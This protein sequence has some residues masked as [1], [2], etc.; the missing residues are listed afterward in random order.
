MSITVAVQHQT[1]YTFD[2]PVALS[3]HLIRLRPA[4]HCRTPIQSYS[5]KISPSKYFIN[6]QQ[7]PFGNYIARVVFPE[8]VSHLHIDVEVIADMTI[9]N[10]FDFF[11]EESAEH[12]PFTYDNELQTQLQPYLQIKEDGPLLKEWLSKVVRS[13]TPVVNFLVALNQRLQ[14]DIGYLIREEPGVQSCEQTLTLKTGSC[15]DS[16]WLLVQIMRHLGMAAR[17]VS[18]Y[19]VQLR[20]D[21]EALD[22]PSGPTE[23]FTDLHAW[24][25]VYI[26]GAGWVG[27]DPTSGLFA[28]E[29]HIPLSCTPSPGA[30][31]PVTGALEPCGSTLEFI[32]RV[33][34]LHE[35]TRVTA[36][37]SEEAWQEAMAL[38]EQIDA[39]LQEHDIRLTQ[40]G[41]PTFIAIDYPD[42]AEWHTAAMG[43]NKARLADELLRRLQ[44]R[45]A[46]KGLLHRGQGKW[47]P[48]EQ[49]PRWAFNCFF[50]TDGHPL[51]HDETLISPEKSPNYGMKQARQFLQTLCQKLGVATHAIM[52]A[53]EDA[54]W[55][56][57]NEADLPEDIDLR[58]TDLDDPL[59]RRRLVRLL[60]KGLEEAT[61]L[62]LP[63]TRSAQDENWRA[64]PWPLRR[65]RLILVTG[66]S[67]MGYRLPL[68]SLPWRVQKDR[69]KP[70]RDS[71]ELRPPLLSAEDIAQHYSQT[72][73][74]SLAQIQARQMADEDVDSEIP[75]T[76]LCVEIRDGR[77]CIFLPPL[78]HLEHFIELVTHIEATAKSCKLTIDLEGYEPPHDPRLRKLAITPDPGVIE[79]NIHPAASWQELVENTRILYE[80]ARLSRLSA[81][82][83]ML[84][85]RH[86]GTGGG[87]HVT[88][89]A[90]EPADSPFLRRPELLG[91]LVLYWQHHPSLSYL[92]SG[93][94]IGPTSQAPR[95][96]EARD[97]TLYDLEIALQQLQREDNISPWVVDRLFRNILVDMTGNTHR[98]EFCIDK[99]YNPG[100]PTGRLGLLELRAFEMPPHYQMSA[101]QM[102][103]LRA[104][105]ARFWQ[106]PYTGRPA[107]WGSTL[108]DRF[109]LPHYV[110]QDFNQVIAE[111]REAGF[112]IERSWYEAFFNFRFPFYGELC[113]RDVR[114][115]LRAAIEPWNVLGEEVSAQGTSRYV[116]SSVERL[117]VKINKWNPQRYALCCN[118]RRVPLQACAT[119]GDYV[120]GIRFKAWQPAFGLHPRLPAH[121]QLVFDV[122]DLANQRSIAGCTYHV[123]HPGGRNFEQLPVNANEAEARRVARFEARGHTQGP[124]EIPE[125]RINPRTPCTLDLRYV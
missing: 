118:G 77:L 50:R 54:A 101:V 73:A 6:W 28:G 13:E 30:A 124:M 20:A 122:V 112:K 41:E 97:D 81:E 107:Y 70:E 1:H 105:V 53:Y 64:A 2:R 58:E 87:N 93:L 35:K 91:S 125:E 11:V 76:A 45:F 43:P 119:T 69:H 67:P 121:Q 17:F 4:A 47:Y 57:R 62:V 89:G 3:P 111:L 36:P 14:E 55:A 10:P 120:A 23:D 92:F 61:G 12:Y 94:F 24:A 59:E 72:E 88:L 40:G 90:A 95:I 44:S 9:I 34:R 86:V 68:D 114:M 22:G 117:Q 116:D 25:E 52:P 26:P 16:A 21:T 71:F 75:H 78:S 96:D 79:V 83:F 98:A 115:E 8:K 56:L 123:S 48:G 104:L 103:L 46:P 102:L 60:E 49:L 108:H 74:P 110:E 38:G 5:L 33:M 7:D 113:V 84:D 15:R 82:K 85:G 37:L 63:I 51:W 109:L 31:A 106:T 27:L 100:G 66:D 42:D 39:K 65:G 18:G 32:N 80:E 99:L 29:G 19:L